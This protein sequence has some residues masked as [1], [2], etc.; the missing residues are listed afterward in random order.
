M[1][2]EIMRVYGG[3]RLSGTVEISGGKNAASAILLAA[4]LSGEPCTVDNLP[5]INDVQVMA[6]LLRSIGAEV[7][8]EGRT[9]HIDP[10]HID[11]ATPDILLCSKMRASYYLLG[12]LIGR[13]GSSVVGLPGGCDI[14]SRPI[15]QH[16]KGFEA[17]GASVN[18][19]GNTIV[20][21]AANG[22]FGNE[23]Y[24]D[25]PSVGATINIMLAAVLAKGN[26]EIFGAAKEPHIVDLANF[27]NAMGA[28][29]KGAGTDVIR[30]RGVKKLGGCTYTIIPD[31]IETGT[32]MIAAAATGGD[33]LIKGAIP[34]HMEALSAKLL[35]MGV[36][37]D[38]GM[39]EDSIRVRAGG[40]LR[41]INLQ[42][43]GYPGFP[44]DLQQPMTALLSM[45]RGTSRVTENLFENRFKHLDEI[46]RMGGIS[47]V[48]SNGKGQVANIT[49]VPRLT[50]CP[51]TATDLRAGAALLV[52]G[53]MADGY[54]DISNV[55]F[56]DRG[57]EKI[58][59]KL[60]GLG[61]RIER[62]QTEE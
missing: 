21:S 35:E 60:T 42:T 46:R 10:A 32:I 49:G 22:L 30:I 15:D 8:I 16:I 47:S 26:T 36:R 34:T 4:S 28:S 51:V 27:L 25:M 13:F 5:L 38:E 48:S 31:Q 56:I 58:E 9:M 17:M 57:Y 24:L 41:R 59:D 44:T 12:S 3:S 40:T 19:V 14:G 1:A 50:G 7:V 55:H 43:Q 18:Y 11:R 2:K 6:G 62:L 53:L 33:V 37:V 23:V 29:V 39:E 45:A 61:A 52:A 20:A 54:T